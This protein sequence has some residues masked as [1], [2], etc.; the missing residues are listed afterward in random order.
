MPALPG[1]VDLPIMCPDC[2]AEEGSFHVP[3]CPRIL[4]NAALQEELAR[5]N[6]AERATPLEWQDMLLAVRDY[7]GLPA[8]LTPRETLATLRRLV[9]EEKQR[10]S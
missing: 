2:L 10:G 7:V 3:T 5:K 8:R 1:A 9:D 6:A 4:G